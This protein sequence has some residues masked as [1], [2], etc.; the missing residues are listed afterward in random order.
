MRK[1]LFYFSII[2]ISLV[3]CTNS[4]LKIEQNNSF[5]DE[6]KLQSDS[7][8][9]LGKKTIAKTLRNTKK[10]K[11][12]SLDETP[13]DPPNSA[14][15]REEEPPTQEPPASDPTPTT[16]P[17]DTNIEE[18]TT[19]LDDL[20]ILVNKYRKLPSD[21]V[22]DQLVI[23]NVPFSFEG[24]DMKKQMHKVAAEALERLFQRA[25]EEGIELYALSGYRSY[26]RQEAI[27]NYNAKKFGEKEANTS[28][29]K[30]G[31]SEHQTGLAM[32]I[33]S[34]SVAF[35]LKQSFGD[36]IEGKWLAENVFKFGFIIRYP[37][38]K[39]EITGYIYEPWHIRYVG[40][41]A[42][43]AI[44]NNSITLE[45]Y[46]N[47]YSEGNDNEENEGSSDDGA[48]SD[49]GGSSDDGASSDDGGSSDDSGQKNA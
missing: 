30:P 18:I 4:Q 10:P 19:N 38:Q 47:S 16:P 34:V 7:I 25:K 45:E 48:S 26:K 33:T 23:P 24:Y 28:S 42:A 8:I 29:A 43:T 32:D 17:K 41:E 37:K 2:L 44:M 21:Y 40:I 20:L 1:L 46:L 3:G 11:E 5:E 13:I 49:D 31:H 27:F 15:E 14:E 22:P 36:T 39:E 12:V 35:A 9:T 6:V